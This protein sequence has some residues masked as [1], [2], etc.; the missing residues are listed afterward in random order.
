MYMI[1]VAPFLAPHPIQ[2]FRMRPATSPPPT[3][4]RPDGSRLIKFY[5]GE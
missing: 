3:A 4:M 5:F 2:E 1:E